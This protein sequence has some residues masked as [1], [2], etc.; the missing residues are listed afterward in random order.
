MKTINVGVI[1]WGFMGRVHTLAL[2]GI[3]LYYPDPGFNINLK[4]VCTRRADIARQAMDACGFERCVTDYRELIAMDDIDA[5]SV[6]TPNSMH[7]EMAIAALRRGKHVCIDKPLA[8]TGESALRIAAAAAESDAITHVLYHNRCFPAIRRAKQL[9][10]EGRIG[11]IIEFGARYLHSGSIDPQKRAN[12]KMQGEGGAMKDMGSHILDLCTYLIGYPAR[13]V[14]KTRRLYDE[15]PT[16]DGTTR[17]L[18]DDQAVMILEMANGALGTLE[19]SKIATGAGDDL[20]LEIRGARGGLRWSV[21]EPNYLEYYDC[22]AQGSPVGGLR[23]WT[24]IETMGHFD[25]PGGESLLPKNAVGWERAH[26]QSYY[27]FLRCVAAGRPS[28]CDAAA[29][30]RLQCLIDRLFESDRRGA[31]IDV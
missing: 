25:S 2:R 14:C 26:I 16:A 8:D 30:A 28:D 20:F 9:I 18:G 22:A 3:P 10:D 12:W 29:A 27:D 11:E 23:G 15:R 4:C 19:T 1:G 31:W 21:M 13:A 17:D 7:E 6:C 24:R 5:V